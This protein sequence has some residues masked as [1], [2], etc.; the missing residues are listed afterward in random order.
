MDHS[1]LDVVEMTAIFTS[2]T[3]TSSLAARSVDQRE[4]FLISIRADEDRARLAAEHG[5][6]SQ[7]ARFII[8]ALDTERRMA[9]SGPQV[10][11]LIKPRG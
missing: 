4:H 2:S 3:R 1:R 8:A 11:Q 10:L 6:L 9:A 5:D 7:S